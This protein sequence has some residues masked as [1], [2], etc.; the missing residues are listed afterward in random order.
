LRS[1]VRWFPSDDADWLFGLMNRFF[2][3]QR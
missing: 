1:K 2:G 3:W